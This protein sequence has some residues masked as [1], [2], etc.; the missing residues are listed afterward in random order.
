MPYERAAAVWENS[1]LCVPRDSLLELSWSASGPIQGKECLEV[2]RT[3][4]NTTGYFLCG[5][6]KFKKIGEFRYFRS[7]N[8][9]KNVRNL[10]WRKKHT[11]VYKGEKN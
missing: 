9:G 6:P 7:R 2:R 5:T 3:R 4:K 8:Q 11:Q 10:S 1:F